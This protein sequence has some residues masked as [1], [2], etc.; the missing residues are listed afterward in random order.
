MHKVKGKI[1]SAFENNCN[2]FQKSIKY[3]NYI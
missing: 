3:Y 2:E 1:K